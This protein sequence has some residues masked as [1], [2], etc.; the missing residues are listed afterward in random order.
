MRRTSYILRTL[1][2]VGIAA[3]AI[4]TQASE[5]IAEDTMTHSST[6]QH[7]SGPFDVKLATLEAYNRSDAAMGRRS[8]DKRFHGEL[9]AISQGEMLSVGTARD[10][11]G[12]VA[13]ERV[14]GTLHG[15]SGSF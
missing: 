11:G 15:R 13:I 14:T 5:K 8:I 4:F 10:N 7:A 3:C 1:G 2:A 12:Y 9:D 6:H